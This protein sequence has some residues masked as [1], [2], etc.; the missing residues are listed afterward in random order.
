M[1]AVKLVV[2]AM[3]VVLF[4]G[5]ISLVLMWKQKQ[6]AP[7]EGAFIPTSVA[8]PAGIDP[9][10]ADLPLPKGAKVVEIG[11]ADRMV[12]LLV[13]HADGSLALYQI[14][15]HDGVLTGVVQLGDQAQ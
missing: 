10:Q 7:P 1:K 14:R 3:G 5:L 2:V 13:S 9:Y 8:T 11:S 4:V 12:D 6:G 15:R